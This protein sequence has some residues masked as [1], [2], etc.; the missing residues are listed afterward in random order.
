[1][2]QKLRDT[3]SWY[4]WWF[5]ALWPRHPEMHATVHSDSDPPY[6]AYTFSHPMRF[7]VLDAEGAVTMA[8]ELLLAARELE[9]EIEVGGDED[10]PDVDLEPVPDTATRH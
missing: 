4:R 8:N 7:L 9:D 3:L 5:S 10:H 6:I 1:M 2:L